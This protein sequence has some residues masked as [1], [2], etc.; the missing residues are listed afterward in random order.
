MAHIDKY[1][2]VI[3]DVSPSRRATQPASQTRSRRATPSENIFTFP[4][5]PTV[6][7]LTILLAII[8]F[9][10]MRS[11]EIKEKAQQVSEK[12]E[13]SEVRAENRS[14]KLTGSIGYLYGK[15]VDNQAHENKYYVDTG[16]RR[17]PIVL[18]NGNDLVGRKLELEVKYTN[19]Q[20]YFDILEIKVVE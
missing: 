20:G 6:I 19:E 15:L 5:G 9:S 8:S 18:S 3:R 12:V 13:S 4:L 11:D 14:E 17:I 2:Q 16:D 1:G 10:S 7:I